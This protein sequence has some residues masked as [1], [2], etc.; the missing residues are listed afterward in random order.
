MIILSCLNIWLSPGDCRYTIAA[1]SSLRNLMKKSKERELSWEEF[2]TITGFAGKNHAGS[3]IQ[4]E[5]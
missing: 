1:E 3:R 2:P 5:I 4:Y